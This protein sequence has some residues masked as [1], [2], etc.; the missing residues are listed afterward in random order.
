LAGAFGA[1]AIVVVTV[2]VY[3]IITYMVVSRRQEIGIRLSLGSTRAQIATLVLRES[4]RLLILGLVIG[5][6]STMLS[7][8]AA[9]A[10]LFGLSPTDIATMIAAATV[11]GAAASL[12]AGIP[13]WRASRVDPQVALRCE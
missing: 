10:L 6:P 1:L 3:G 9:S 8:R 4:L 13:A 12:A 5:I 7:M 2:G 11:L